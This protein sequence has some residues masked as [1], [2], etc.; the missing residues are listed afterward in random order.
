[1][2][3]SELA[4]EAAP[5]RPKSTLPARILLAATIW[6]LLAALA[7]APGLAQPPPD[8]GDGWGRSIPAHQGLDDATVQEIFER[9]RTQDDFSTVRGVVIVRHGTLVA[10]R[11]FGGFTNTTL[12]NVHSVSKSVT[13]LA[14]GIALDRGLIPSVDARL[15]DL[16]PHYAHRLAEA[17]KNRLTLRHALTMT[18]GMAWSDTDPAF[19]NNPDSVD[20]VLT[21][22]VVAQ[23]GAEFEYSSGL[24]HVIAEANNR[25]SGLS[26]LAFV[27]KHLFGPLGIATA[28]WDPDLSGRHWGGTGLRI[29][30]R[31]MAKIGQL[32]LQEGLWEGRR[33][34]SREWIA[35]ST[36][37]QTGGIAGA[38]NYGYQWWIRPKGRYLAHG[39]NGQYVGVDP[40]ADIVMTMITLSERSPR[41]QETYRYYFEQLQDLAREAIRPERRGRF[42]TAV[43]APEAGPGPGTIEIEVGRAGG[44]DGAA[45]LAYGTRNGSARA[46]REFRRTE[47]EL[48]WEHGDASARTVEIPLLPGAN[49]EAARDFRVEFES[50]SGGIDAPR[51]MKIE[52]GPGGE[53]ANP[54]GAIEFTGPAFPGREGG[55][56]TIAVERRGG[57]R[58]EVAVSYRTAPRSAAAGVDFGAV[59]GRLAWKDGESGARLIAVPLMA[60][61]EVER[62]ELFDVV[63]GD[64][65]GGAELPEP[66]AVGVIQDTTGG[67]GCTDGDEALC[68][69][70]GRFRVEVEWQAP[71]GRRGVG[72]LSRLSDESG[73]ATFFSPENVELVFKLLDGRSINDHHWVYYGA[74]SDV[75]YWIA[76]TDT[77]H[78]RVVVYR[79]PPGEICGRGDSK[80][81]AAIGGASAAVGGAVL[82]RNVAPAGACRPGALC[83]LDGRFEVT[84]EW[85]KPDGESGAATP[86]PGAG[87]AGYMWFFSPGNIELAVKALDGRTTNNAFWIFAAGLTDVDYELTVTDTVAGR[88]KTY[89]NPSRPFCGLGDTSA[90]PQ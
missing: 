8:I 29:R 43:K 2:A 57:T 1:M 52:L 66:R 50:M 48:R 78:D 33:L 16:I 9:V 82:P 59:R 51:R 75:E 37:G 90:F 30:P 6:A 72:S 79:N 74:L 25:A 28:T 40:E 17:P 77:L 34:V 32:A 4:A 81:F 49:G 44:S 11:Y 56:A 68:L 87:A 23:P 38:P 55:E 10:E 89:T 27:R 61:D 54:P 18:A 12:K 24:S 83:L 26:H 71:D 47:G 80:A 64:V 20:Y 62:S 63:L 69:A 13:S 7:A 65:A 86:L 5:A 53:P 84:A 35:E 31:D 70:G 46:G 3:R 21:R 22:Q 76:V 39:Y 67:P 58:G 15:A 60:D 42:T 19:W 36:R 88:S 14:T 41:P 73:V 45:T 85:S